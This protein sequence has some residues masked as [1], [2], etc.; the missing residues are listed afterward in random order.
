[1]KKLDPFHWLEDVHKKRLR[2]GAAMG[3]RGGDLVKFPDAKELSSSSG[4]G[5]KFQDCIH[6][7][8]TCLS[9]HTEI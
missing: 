5:D 3:K 2:K 9:F 8:I 1:M 6:C 7:I 4:P